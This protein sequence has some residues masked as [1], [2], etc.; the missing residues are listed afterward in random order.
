MIQEEKLARSLQLASWPC[1][2]VESTALLATLFQSVA[3]SADVSHTKKS[4]YE[5]HAIN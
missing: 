3:S 4:G 2:A 1:C 5:I